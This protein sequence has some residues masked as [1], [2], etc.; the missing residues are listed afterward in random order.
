M[1]AQ[2]VS[3]APPPTWRRRRQ[4]C[5]VS[6]SVVR[7]D[8]GA[9]CTSCATGR[10]HFPLSRGAWS[11]PHRHK[12]R[13]DG[14]PVISSVSR[15]IKECVPHILRTACLLNRVAGHRTEQVLLA[16]NEHCLLGGRGGERA[17]AEIGG[18]HHCA[19]AGRDGGGGEA[20]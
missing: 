11:M 12:H 7:Q 13:R 9:R 2:T 18:A 1:A 3:G 8:V 20:V 17:E 6:T 19:S 15:A 16:P 5:G 4:V 14:L 10:A